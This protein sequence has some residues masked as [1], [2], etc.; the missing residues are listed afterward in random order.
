M[1][2]ITLVS[3]ETKLAPY[4]F[5]PEIVVTVRIPIVPEE[6]SV[7]DPDFHKHFGEEFMSV[8]TDKKENK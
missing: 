4:T 2:G 6:K 8:L 1:I 3:K 5:A 7:P